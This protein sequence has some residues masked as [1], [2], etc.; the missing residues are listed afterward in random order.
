MIEPPSIAGLRPRLATSA[1]GRRCQTQL[2]KA[3]PAIASS[4]HQTKLDEVPASDTVVKAGRTLTV[5]ALEVFAVTGDQRQLV[6]M[7]QQTLFCVQ[8]ESRTSRT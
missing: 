2:R 7:G 1:R 8:P 4:P 3:Q 6:A 5:C